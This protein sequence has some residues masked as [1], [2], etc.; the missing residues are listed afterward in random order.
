MPKLGESVVEGTVGRWLKQ[1]GE[2]IARYE[3]LLEVETDKVATEVPAPISGT[4]RE[5]IV[6]EGTTVRVGTVIAILEDE[7]ALRTTMGEG[8]KEREAEVRANGETAAV[9]TAT[10]EDA[11]EPAKFVS[12][13]VARMAAE[14]GLDLSQISGTGLGGRVSKK[15]VERF[16]ASIADS[17]QP[18]ADSQQPS[19]P[20]PASRI[21]H[22]SDDSE[23]V[24]LSPMRRAIAEHMVRSVHTAP[25][26]TTVF[27]CDLGR[28]VAHREHQRAAFKHQGARLTLT[29]YFVQAVV[30]GL[31]A[32]PAL[33]STWAEQGILRHRRAHVGVAVALD[34]GLIVPVV[35]DADEKNLLG[36]ARAVGDVAE[37][38]RARKLQPGETEGGTFTLTN[39][40][41]SG[42]L[43]ATPIINQ[44]QSAI[45]GVGAVQK[46]PVVRSFE[47]EDFIAI[48]PM[49]YLSLTFDHRVADGATADRFLQAVKAFLE[50]YEQ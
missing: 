4:V 45:L 40:G 9:R 13:V 48:R 10:R 16:L 6:P 27:E 7:E 19:A 29:A 38:A 23:L 22:P 11:T 44:P 28:V 2:R 46:R 39:H 50:G 41:T 25:H 36:L 49:C 24:P 35:R 42:S 20:H 3:A 5:L 47:G 31:R 43:F 37:R 1:P 18:I 21:P 12:P 33:N 26:V 32:E 30:A 14:H 17:R 8:A 15:D 34:E